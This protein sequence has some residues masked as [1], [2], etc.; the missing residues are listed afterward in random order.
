MASNN[1]DRTLALAGV[2]QAASLVDQIAHTGLCDSD[3]LEASIDSVLR[4]DAPDAAAVFGSVGGVSVGLRA[5]IGRS[6]QRDESSTRL[7]RYVVSLLHLERR[8]AKRP[9]MLNTVRDGILGA[10]R[11]A[12][13]FNSTH[14][15]VIGALGNIYEQTLS[16]FRFRIQI[17]GNQ[18]HLSN[19]NNVSKIRALLLAGVRA[20]VLYHQRGGRT[21]TPL[22]RRKALTATAQQLL[23]DNAAS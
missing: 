18:T 1:S 23:E 19:P 12:E 15:A 16:T 8:L 9:E 10:Q 11:Q 5:L 3:A 17:S 20:A 22:L 7:V 21:W 6:Q 13:H 4:I 14:P 2:W